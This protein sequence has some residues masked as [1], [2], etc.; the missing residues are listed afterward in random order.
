MC[1]LS[2]TLNVPYRK[3]KSSK[4]VISSVIV[5][6]LSTQ[7]IAKT[8]NSFNIKTPL[9]SFEINSSRLRELSS[10][11]C[12]NFTLLKCVSLFLVPLHIIYFIHNTDIFS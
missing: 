12:I 7:I 4:L 10:N 11:N 1:L 3:F 2:C 8:L 9:H 5:S 6:L